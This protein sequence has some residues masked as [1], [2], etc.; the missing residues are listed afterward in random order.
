ML[1]F[2]YKRDLRD[3]VSLIYDS[4]FGRIVVKGAVQIKYIFESR[5]PPCSVVFIEFRLLFI[6]FYKVLFEQGL[7][8]P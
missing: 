5:T 2:R 3:F 1:F 6:L 7:V 4:L 8:F